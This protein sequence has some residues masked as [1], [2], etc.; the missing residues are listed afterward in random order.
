M[1]KEK[2]QLK[3]RSMQD[4]QEQTF[5]ISLNKVLFPQ[6]SSRILYVNVSVVFYFNQSTILSQKPTRRKSGLQDFF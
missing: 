6:E 4:K 5:Y 1:K 3:G 2:T